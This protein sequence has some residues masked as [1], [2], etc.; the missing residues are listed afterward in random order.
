MQ[1]PQNHK[2]RTFWLAAIP[3]LALLLVAAWLWG[4]GGVIPVRADPVTLYVDTAAGIDDPACGTTAAP[5]Q[6]ISY[7]LHTR[8]AGGDMIRVAQGVY[9]ENLSVNIS[10]TLEGGYEA[11]GWTRDLMLYETVLDGGGN[12]TFWGD[13]DGNS[14]YAPAVISDGGQF[15]MWYSGQMLDGTTNFGLATSPEGIT[16]TKSLSNPL[17]TGF[18]AVVLKEAPGDYKMW[19]TRDHGVIGRAISSDGL[20]WETDP[21]E[22]FFHP[23]YQDG[24]WDRDL[25]SDPSIVQDAGGMYWMFYE[26]ANWDW[27]QVQIGVVTST[28]GINWTCPQPD[29]VLIPGNSG[30]WDEMW[31]LD[32]MVTYEGGEFKM[33][34][35]GVDNDDQRRIG[36]A[37]SSDGLNW[38]KDTAHNPVFSGAPGE[39]DEG[40]VG[41]HAL[42]FEG[43]YHLWYSSNGQIGYIT[44]TNGIT[45]TRGLISPVLSPGTPGQWGSPVIHVTSGD[46][47]VVL[48]GLT[49]TGGNGEM[50]GGVHG[51]SADLTLQNCTIR[52]NYGNGAPSNQGA[53]GVLGGIGGGSVTI[54]DSSIINNQVGEG[55]SGVRVHQGSLAIT[56]TLVADNHG[57]NGIHVNGPLA[58]TNVTVANNDGGVTFNPAA[59]VVMTAVNSIFY[60]NAGIWTDVGVVQVSYSDIEGGW[61]GEGNI[62]VDPW[63]VDPANGDYHLQPWSPAI[64]SGTTTN[65]PDHDFEGDSRPL[66]SGVDMGADEYRGPPDPYPN[67]G[68]RYVDKPTGSDA[69]P[70]LCLDPQAPCQTIAHALGMAVDGDLVLV[71]GSPVAT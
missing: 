60:G 42:V 11:T 19:F 8:A 31:V 61:A 45:W 6:T 2:R 27:N 48:N 33:W 54:I 28:D 15:E 68:T 38:T 44:S 49:I 41:N 35:S 17:Q 52:D 5:C 18:E 22:L 26:G 65:A 37:T 71:T 47:V 29:P 70:N 10:I 3:L 20:S 25:V 39:W 30:D 46:V 1:K 9:T 59:G 13:W 16:W 43:D 14:I 50:V 67:E 23:T 69:G 66:F 4:I 40:H 63:F 62:D 53:G 64:D 21:A 7:T 32:P 34:Y 51:E 55:A 58:L 36:Y 24:T 56:N 12:P 57:D